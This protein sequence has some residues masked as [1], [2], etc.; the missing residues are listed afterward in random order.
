MTNDIDNKFS[1]SLPIISENFLDRSMI[2]IERYS[3]VTLFFLIF[4]LLFLTYGLK[5]ITGFLIIASA[6]LGLIIFRKTKALHLRYR[7][8]LNRAADF[9]EKSN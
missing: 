1:D 5:L 8:L 6:C 9:G 7:Q 3:I 2:N 4:A